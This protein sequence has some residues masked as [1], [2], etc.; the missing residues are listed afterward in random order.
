MELSEH[1]L[2]PLGSWLGFDGACG[3]RRPHAVLTVRIL[4]GT[5]MLGLVLGRRSTR[6]VDFDAV[7][8]T[9]A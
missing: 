5:L 8:F 4:C 7:I 1:Y 9:F 6:S 3:Q 2:A